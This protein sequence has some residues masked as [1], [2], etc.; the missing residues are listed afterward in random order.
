FIKDILTL[1]REC[2]LDGLDLDWEFPA[3]QSDKYERVHFT[4]LLMEIRE[5]LER[6]HSKLILSVA[7]AAPQPIIDASY[8]VSYMAQYVD[9][10]NVMTY[11]FHFYTTYLPMT[12]YNAPLYKSANETG[13]FATLNT[14]W[15]ISYW[16]S[17]GMPKEK[18][19]VGLPTYGHSFTLINENNHG[20]GAPASGFGTFGDKGFISYPE[21][22]RF[23]SEGSDCVFDRDSRVPYAFKGTEWIS[24][25]DEKSLAYKAWYVLNG[26][27]GGAMIWSLNMDDFKGECS[28]TDQK[29]FPLITKVKMVLED[30]SLQEIEMRLTK[31]LN[32]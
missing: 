32:I 1:L 10:V 20:N 23:V 29:W 11:D 9:Y 15:S 17:K 21:A 7:V 5:E 16:Q 6:R 31:A 3:W 30:N 22:C 26:S 13:Y 4:Q 28:T 12:G 19:V 24:Y 25:D 27:Y 18:I 14:N 8:D 2:A